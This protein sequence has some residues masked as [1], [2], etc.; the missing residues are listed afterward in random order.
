MSQGGSTTAHTSRPGIS[1]RAGRTRA[2][3]GSRYRR[4]QSYGVLS[5]SLAVQSQPC[6]RGV[7]KGGDSCG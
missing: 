5:A 3:V 7:G 1:S 4:F 2:Y 6:P